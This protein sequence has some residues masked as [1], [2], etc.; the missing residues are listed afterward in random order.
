MPTVAT[1]VMYNVKQ[2]LTRSG[3]RRMTILH[4][5]Q[6]KVVFLGPTAILVRLVPQREAI[7]IVEPANGE[8]EREGGRERDT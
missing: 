1:V 7:R 6:T 5:F 4:D 3:T 8:R 2:L